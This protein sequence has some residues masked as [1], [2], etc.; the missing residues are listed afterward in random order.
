MGRVT[1][2]G[3]SAEKLKRLV[4][5]A[6][7]LREHITQTFKSTIDTKSLKFEDLRQ[8]GQFRKNIEE[9]EQSMFRRIKQF[10]LKSGHSR[11]QVLKD[12]AFNETD[13]ERFEQIMN[14]EADAEMGGTDGEGGF[15]EEG[16]GGFDEEGEESVG[17][18]TGMIKSN[19]VK[20]QGAATPN[21]MIASQKVAKAG[22][23][24]SL[25]DE[26]SGAS[27][28]ITS[29]KTQTGANTKDFKHLQKHRDMINKKMAALSQNGGVNMEIQNKIRASINKIEA[30]LNNLADNH[31]DKPDNYSFDSNDGHEGEEHA[32]APFEDTDE[33]SGKME[34]QASTSS[35]HRKS[36][37]EIAAM[38]MSLNGDDS[39]EEVEKEHVKRDSMRIMGSQHGNGSLGGAKGQYGVASPRASGFKPQASQSPNNSLNFGVRDSASGN[40][41]A[42]NSKTG[43]QMGGFKS[44]QG[45]TNSL[46]SN[47]SGRSN[48]QDKFLEGSGMKAFKADSYGSKNSAANKKN[49]KNSNIKNSKNFNES[50]AQHSQNSLK[51]LLQN[52]NESFDQNASQSRSQ[53]GF[54]SS[55]SNR[56]SKNNG[57]VK[58]ERPLNDTI[59]FGTNTTKRRSNEKFSELNNSSNAKYITD[60]IN[61]EGEQT[62]NTPTNGND[63]QVDTIET[64][65]GTVGAQGIRNSLYGSQNREK[66][67]QGGRSSNSPK[68]EIDH[69]KVI[70]MQPKNQAGAQNKNQNIL[71]VYNARLSHNMLKVSPDVENLK[72]KKV[73]VEAAMNSDKNSG[74]DSVGSR[75]SRG[76]LDSKGRG[77]NAKPGSLQV[78][79]RNPVQ[80][81]MNN[82][83]VSGTG[84]GATG[85]TSAGA[86]SKGSTANPQD[87][88]LA[89]TK[90]NSFHFPKTEPYVE[91]DL[92]KLNDELIRKEIN[93]S[94][95]KVR[96]MEEE[97]QFELGEIEARASR[98]KKEIENLE[99]ARNLSQFRDKSESNAQPDVFSESGAK[100]S[101]GAKTSTSS[102]LRT[103]ESVPNKQSVVGDKTLAEID[104]RISNLREELEKSE[105]EIQYKKSSLVKPPEIF[106]EDGRGFSVS[107]NKP[108]VA[109]N[110]V[111]LS[112]SNPQNIKNPNYNQS[113]AEQGIDRK[114]SEETFGPGT[115]NLSPRN[116][117]HEDSK[118]ILEIDPTAHLKKMQTNSKDS[119]SGYNSKEDSQFDPRESV[120]N[121]LRIS[122]ESLAGQDNRSFAKN[123]STNSSKLQASNPLGTVQT[124]GIKTSGVQQPAQ[125]K[126][127]KPGQSTGGIVKQGSISSQ[128][129]AS[130]TVQASAKKPEKRVVVTNQEIDEIAENHIEEIATDYVFKKSPSHSIGNDSFNKE[131]GADTYEDYHTD[132]GPILVEFD[133]KSGVVN[134]GDPK[135]LT[136][137][138]GVNNSQA[139]VGYDSKD[140][141]RQGGAKVSGGLREEGV[142]IMSIGGGT[143]SYQGPND[144]GAIKLV[145]FAKSTGG[146]AQLSNLE[147]V[148]SG[149][150]RSSLTG[151][152]DQSNTGARAS[153]EIIPPQVI[154]DETDEMPAEG[155]QSF[156]SH[157][158]FDNSAGLNVSNK[159]GKS[160]NQTASKPSGSGQ[161]ANSKIITTTSTTTTSTGANAGKLTSSQT[162][163]SGGQAAQRQQIQATTNRVLTDSVGRGG[164]NVNSISGSQTRPGFDSTDSRVKQS[165]Q[166]S[167]TGFESKASTAK[168]GPIPSSEDKLLYMGTKLQSDAEGVNGRSG[169][170]GL[171]TYENSL[172]GSYGPEGFLSSGQGGRQADTSGQAA[173]FKKGQNNSGKPMAVETVK[174]SIENEAQKISAAKAVTA[175]NSK[176]SSGQQMNAS[177][178]VVS[179]GGLPKKLQ[180]D[181]NLNSNNSWNLNSIK[182][183]ELANSGVKLSEGVATGFGAIPSG[184]KNFSEINESNFEENLR[185]FGQSLTPMNDSKSFRR[186]ELIEFEEK[187]SGNRLKEL[188]PVWLLEQTAKRANTVWVD[189]N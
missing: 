165:L 108:S 137:F 59:T 94:Y 106:P 114:S 131:D 17:A 187:R 107:Q 1:L 175:P 62:K 116:S 55:V 19:K 104:R 174:N 57:S 134:H 34:R 43:G 136:K 32:Q 52:Q 181:S 63:F 164:A 153:K 110:N 118:E 166:A 126:T 5:K 90:G 139:G 10:V 75:K 184:N 29:Q 50:G 117:S 129:Q 48:S 156:G 64:K 119:V 30:D 148:E 179:E 185:I 22:G 176:H 71:N 101:V 61:I 36:H 157:R 109:K 128:K 38:R 133:P 105:A 69:R 70:L 146:N 68:R 2:T 16:E 111:L 81:A 186:N 113:V 45:R 65:G 58:V 162:D 89:I 80:A 100:R 82:A 73:T 60:L 4:S 99:L 7:E 172:S 102:Q 53:A 98:I 87:S 97:E 155:Y 160:G 161:A 120:K 141:V 23:I 142:D 56:M 103:V 132:D 112:Q 9:A 86:K 8:N 66:G 154:Y 167:K 152:G 76:S 169:E 44:G 6:R 28:P 130:T 147:N 171:R 138:S 20:A 170:Y 124:S 115:P 149:P 21:R 35:H 51:N 72:S 27:R 3:E 31:G 33:P 145:P 84:K 123:G 92:Q 121:A 96:K 183:P 41:F 49:L 95:V 135:N 178:Q 151:S 26:D 122:K 37:D 42:N 78:A 67:I 125:N 46:G 83:K 54:Q 188:F 39:I 182:R 47:A 40:R 24:F 150:K 180:V 12:L 14:G 91:N 168:N 140:S 85:A 77:S 177:L 15:E 74:R 159:N 173:A 88:N 144:S 163:R 11:Q 93:D 18:K 143:S 158:A 189:F 25:D 13:A 127:S 79:T